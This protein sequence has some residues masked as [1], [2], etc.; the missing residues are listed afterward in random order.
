MNCHGSS[1]HIAVDID[2]CKCVFVCVRVRACKSCVSDAKFR[3]LANF[4]FIM[5][6]RLVRLGIANV[7]DWWA[8]CGAAMAMATKQLR[9]ASVQNTLEVIV[10]RKYARTLASFTRT[11]SRTHTHVHTHTHTHARTQ[12]QAHTTTMYPTNHH[13]IR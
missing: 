4:G 5:Y 7:S 9:L 12:T 10:C 2:F 11:Y 3:L 1:N 13:F 6:M 8:C